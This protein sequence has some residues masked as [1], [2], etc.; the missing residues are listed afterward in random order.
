MAGWGRFLRRGQED[1]GAPAAQPASEWAD[2]VR[3]RGVPRGCGAAA[4]QGDGDHMEHGASARGAGS[5]RGQGRGA[6]SDN[7]GGA[8]STGSV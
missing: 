5:G 4:L 7:G 2:L 8:Q 6:R 3:G 1:R